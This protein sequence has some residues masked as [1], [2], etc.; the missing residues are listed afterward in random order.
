MLNFNSPP[1]DIPGMNER[2][3]ERER[4]D[5][6]ELVS[7]L[8]IGFL[9]DIKFISI[10]EQSSVKGTGMQFNLKKLFSLE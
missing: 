9:R 8:N 4:S 10:N 7:K 5:I 2:E 6:I 3:R 1:I